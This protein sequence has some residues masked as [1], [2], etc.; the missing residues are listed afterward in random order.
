VSISADTASTNV[1]RLQ[2]LRVLVAGPDRR[3]VRVTAFLLAL[4]AYDISE[5]EI[6]QAVVDAERTRADVVVVEAGRSR[7]ESARI[8]A[9]LAALPTAP[10]VVVVTRDG[11]E[12]WDG[13]RTLAKWS[14]VDQVVTLIEDAALARH[15][16]EAAEAAQS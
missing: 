7:A 10:A 3:F 2:P 8:V 1:R 4:R 6:G 16:P 13:Q 5:S 9:Q 11:K 14:P 15:M 12:L